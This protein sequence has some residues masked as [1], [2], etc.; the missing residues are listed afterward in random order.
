MQGQVW[1]ETIRT[2]GQLDYMVFPRLLALAERATGRT[3]R[4][5]PRATAD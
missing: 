5:F 2:S 3:G 4:A 1:S